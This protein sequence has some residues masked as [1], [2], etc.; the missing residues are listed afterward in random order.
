MAG[1]FLELSSGF[2]V[3]DR[4]LILRFDANFEAKTRT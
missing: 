4:R 2:E 1:I 3:T